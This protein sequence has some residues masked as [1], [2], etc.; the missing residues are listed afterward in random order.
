MVWRMEGGDEEAVSLLVPVLPF[1]QG[2]EGVCCIW[3]LMSNADVTF[4][5]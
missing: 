3:G 5:R 2:G 4:W 1:P